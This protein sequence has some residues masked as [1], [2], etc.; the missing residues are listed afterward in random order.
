VGQA[1]D[2]LE[3]IE[4]TERLKPDIGLMDVSMPQVDGIQATQQIL[5]LPIH[6]DLERFI[7][8]FM[9]GGPF[10]ADGDRNQVAGG[11]DG[12]FPPD[13]R[14]PQTPGCGRVS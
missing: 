4:L 14:L 5:Q 13:G 8:G 9:L 3:A 12:S 7:L 10:R 2:G 11:R 6:D 1:A